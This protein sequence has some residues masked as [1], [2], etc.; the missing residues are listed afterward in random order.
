MLKFWV[1]P[2]V[3]DAPCHVTIF[4]STCLSQW[5]IKPISITQCL[6]TFHSNNDF[7]YA[8][9]CDTIM[10]PHAS[11]WVGS[12][13]KI[14]LSFLLIANDS[15]DAVSDHFI[16]GDTGT[17]LWFYNTC[18]AAEEGLGSPSC[19]IQ[20]RLMDVYLVSSCDQR[21]IIKC[22]YIYWGMTFTFYANV[23]TNLLK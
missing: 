19:A 12:L 21:F 6:N 16:H 14:K 8:F 4:M 17:I 1:L 9:H 10:K 15:L 3:K 20:E 5:R 23:L 18:V 7:F 22:L 13:P 2:F 11:A